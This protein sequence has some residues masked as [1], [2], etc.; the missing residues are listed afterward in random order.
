[1]QKISFHENNAH[2]GIKGDF[3]ESFIIG[4]SPPDY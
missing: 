3:Y 1:M 4:I 2:T